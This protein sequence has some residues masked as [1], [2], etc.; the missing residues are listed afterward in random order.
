MMMTQGGLSPEYAHQLG[1]GSSEGVT[2]WLGFIGCVG[3]VFFSRGGA[4]LSP[5]FTI[6]M[7]IVTSVSLDMPNERNKQSNPGDATVVVPSVM[8]DSFWSYASWNSQHND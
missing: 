6:T 3:G 2:L 5:A 7:N 8:Y 1:R 4:G